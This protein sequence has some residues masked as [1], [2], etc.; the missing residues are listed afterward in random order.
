MR[1]R[2]KSVSYGVHSERHSRFRGS[3]TF[4]S[5]AELDGVMTTLRAAFQLTDSAEVSIEVDPRTVT[6]RRLGHLR[7]MGFSRVS[8][9]VQDFDAKVQQAV[10]RVQPFHGLCELVHI[11]RSLGF[12]STNADLIYGLPLQKPE[13]FARTIAQIGELRPDRIALYAYAHLPQRFEPQRRI[14]AAE[15]PNGTDRVAMLGGAIAVPR[16]RLYLRRHGP[17]RARRIR[18]GGGQARGSPAPKVSGLQHAARL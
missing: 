18:T 2:S 15:L 8:F 16:S 4:L 10:H 3:L 17:L 13:S 6:P 11:A 14:V 9:G 1:W 5:D 12:E 7:E